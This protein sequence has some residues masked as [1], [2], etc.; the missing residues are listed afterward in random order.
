MMQAE[1]MGFNPKDDIKETELED[2]ANNSLSKTEVSA[3]LL[4]K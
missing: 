1:E 3:D 2:E 4:T